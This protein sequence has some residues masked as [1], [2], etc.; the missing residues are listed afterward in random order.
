MQELGER[1]DG[2]EVHIRTTPSFACIQ[3]LSGKHGGLV[4]L[5][6]KGDQWRKGGVRKRLGGEDDDCGDK[7][8]I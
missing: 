1:K 7:S 6:H 5:L 3:L 8:V 2:G 4:L